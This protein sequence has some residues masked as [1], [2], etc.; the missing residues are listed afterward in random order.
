MKVVMDMIF[1]HCGSSHWWLKDFPSSDWL[2]NQDNFV[3]TNHF[4]WTLMDVHAPQ[5]EREILVN[6][7][8]G[9]G[10]PDLNQKIGT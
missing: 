6:G 9:R 3:Q 8:F 5:S 7:W 1:N 2:N 4:K 10:M